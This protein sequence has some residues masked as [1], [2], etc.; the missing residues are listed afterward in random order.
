MESKNI[1]PFETF[2]RSHFFT[3]KIIDNEE[4]EKLAKQFITI[5]DS[6][7]LIDNSTGE[8]FY[9]IP[10]TTLTKA[11]YQAEPNNFNKNNLEALRQMLDEKIQIV[12]KVILS[13]PKDTDADTQE[14]NKII[15]HYRSCYHRM[16][17]HVLLART[18][19]EYM[20][21]IASNLEKSSKKAMYVAEE[22]E[23]KSKDITVQFVT[24]LGIFATIIVA[25]FGGMSLTR[26]TVDLLMKEGSLPKF[27]FIISV[28]M[29]CFIS[30]I[31]LL[32]SWIAAINTKRDDKYQLYKGI[33]FMVF[34]TLLSVSAIA[35]H[36]TKD[37]DF[38]ES[39]TNNSEA[40]V[41]INIDAIDKKTPQ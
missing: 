15:N 6:E 27:A 8:T 18:Q 30:L 3:D 40:K 2:I 41:S 31:G 9:K 12:L 37:N 36:M 17:E 16:I 26:A 20:E 10:Y 7:N 5:C 22:A 35:M 19:K 25:L 11:I 32:I 14:L 28:L 21:E 24:I 13:Q 39:K 4:G 1:K 33:I 23:K 38:H 34:A 29:L